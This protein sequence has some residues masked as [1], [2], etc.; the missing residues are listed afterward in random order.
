MER[1]DLVIKTDADGNGTGYVGVVKLGH[2]WAIRY[3]KDDYDNGVGIVVTAEDSGMEILTLT[4]MNA[5]VTKNPRGDAH[6]IADGSDALYASQDQ[7]V[8]VLIPIA[9]ER[10]KIVVSGGG[11]TKSGLF[12]IWLD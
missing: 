6:N 2:I 1:V 9:Y 8:K 11:D 7:P 3:V 4:N 5:S 12:H 10:I